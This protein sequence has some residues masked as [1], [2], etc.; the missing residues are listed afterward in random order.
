MAAAK[1]YTDEELRQLRQIQLD[2]YKEI[3]S[4]CQRHSIP[5]VA[6]GGS[7]LG[8]L[9][10]NGYIPWDDDLDVAMLRE[11]YVS[12]LRYAQQELSP[13]YFIQNFDTDPHYGNYFTKI[14]CNGTLFVQNIDKKDQSHHG[15]FVDI[16]PI[17][18]LTDQ[19]EERA[20]YRRRLM[21]A[22]QM[23]L[24]KCN[25]GI[26]GETESLSGKL[27]HLI[28][29]SL[30]VL[31]APASKEKLFRSVDR[32]SQS[33]NDKKPHTLMISVVYAMTG[34]CIDEALVFPPAEHPFEGD[35]ICV[36]HDADRYLSHIYGDYMKLPP[37]EKRINH[38]PVKLSFHVDP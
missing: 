17:D 8:A 26:T 6:I 18:R 27:K 2:I 32:L 7:A 36:P 5:H 28:R 4:I 30:H 9:R 16:F 24:A 19:V 20:G 37:V 33:Y 22:Y 23:Y 35:T 13:R 38:R 3:R 21:L 29:A 25:S 1:K 34:R 10:H 14:R 31:L 11:D 12:F 15:I